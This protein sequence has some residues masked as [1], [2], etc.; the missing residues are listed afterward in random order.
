MKSNTI[1]NNLSQKNKTKRIKYKINNELF[2][3]ED[4]IKDCPNSKFIPTIL[5]PTK[6]IIAIGD[7]HGDLNLAIRSFKLAKLIDDNFNWVANPPCTIVVQ[8]GDQI[9]SCRPIPGVYDCHTSKY[10]ND[11]AEDMKIIDF[12]NKIHEKANAVGG[13]VYS[14]LGNHE[15]MNVEGRFDY[16]SYD[17]FY[18]FDYTT[19]DGKKYQGPEG[20]I[21][22]FKPGGPVSK[23]LACTRLSVLVIGSSMFVHAGV[24]P[25]LAKRLDYLSI[26][27]ETKLKYLNAIVR[28]W[29]LKKLSE[30]DIENKEMF[31]NNL[32]ISPFWTRIY[33]TIPEHTSLDSSECFRSVKKVIEVFK[34]GQLV[35]GHTPQLF[36][37]KNGI[38]GTCYEQ[39]GDGD[40]KLYRVDG[41]FSKA[42][43]IFDNQGLVQV[44]EI[45]D[46]KK[47]NILTDKGIEKYI[48]PPD[49]NINEKE[50]EN[51]SHLYAQNRLFKN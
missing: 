21:E 35:V 31:V 12:F 37:N 7:I 40:K 47:F 23:M 33:G 26:D 4:F 13:A 29:L 46:D 38:N 30:N 2:D 44:L 34:I 36:T 16:V 11:N 50:I 1:K 28:K 39:S 24:L 3:E 42:F 51:I 18:N 45:I 27:N 5:P 6:R 22:S 14:L 41:G 19:I 25:I 48:E 17:N 10:P 49:I 8:V 15:L 20:R 32:S 43:N 9:D